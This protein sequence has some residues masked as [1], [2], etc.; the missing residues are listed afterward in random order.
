MD[1]V[2]VFLQTA[3]QFSQQHLLKRL[4]FL[5]CIFLVPLSKEVGYS[6]TASYPG[7]LFGST[8][9]QHL[10][11]CH[12]ETP[13]TT[14]IWVIKMFLK[15]PYNSYYRPYG[16]T[17]FNVKSSAFTKTNVMFL[18]LCFCHKACYFS[19]FVNS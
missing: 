7:P 10:W 16:P 9:L 12:N 8:G 11:K 17:Q 13:C 19:S 5:Y 15:S 2:S 6:C 4:S 3:N 1:L 18:K 14:I